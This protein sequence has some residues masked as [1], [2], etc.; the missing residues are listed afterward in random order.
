TF[1]LPHK[2]MVAGIYDIFNHICEQYFSG[3]DDNTSDYLAEGLMRSVVHSSLIAVENPQDYDNVAFFY[4]DQIFRGVTGTVAAKLSEYTH[5]PTIVAAKENNVYVGSM[6]GTPGISFVDFLSGCADLLELFGGHH[7]AAGFT[8]DEKHLEEF[9]EYLHQHGA[10]LR[11]VT[12][13]EIREIDAEIPLSYLNIDLFN[14]ICVL[15]PLGQNNEAPVLFTQGIEISDIITMGKTN[16][17]VKIAFKTE[18]EPFFGIWWNKAD[19]MRKLH[20]PGNKYNVLYTIEKNVFHNAV[21]LQM[22]IIDMEVM[23]L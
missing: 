8:L 1:T 14:R 11:P 13:H 21:T 6:R 23:K 5:L 7:D 10:E 15:E 9:R 12:C 18:K 4:S 3:T 17:H 20:K 19:F 2:Q 22:N 16:S